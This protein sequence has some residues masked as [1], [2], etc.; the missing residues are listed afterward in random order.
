MNYTS[1]SEQQT[2]DIAKDFV[3]TLKGGEVIELVGDLGAGKTVFVRGIVEAFG[4]DAR[5]K[6]PTFTIM[7]EYPV[8]GEKVK[9]I[10]H[11][12]LYRFNN[13]SQ[14]SALELDEVITDDSVAC[15]EWP[16]I[17]GESP[18]FPTHRIKIDHVDEE[19]REIE[20]ENLS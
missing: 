12:D 8:R 19:T 6:S 2:K 20:I 7:N 13:A 17:F 4:S 15:I 5:V 11:I 10:V 1:K 16:D 9:K 3:K 14:L 18:F